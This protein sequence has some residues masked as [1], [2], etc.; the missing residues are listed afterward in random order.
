MCNVTTMP[1]CA[2]L[3]VCIKN[4][5]LAS[6]FTL[7]LGVFVI[8]KRYRLKLDLFLFLKHSSS[9]LFDFWASKPLNAKENFSLQCDGHFGHKINKMWLNTDKFFKPEFFFFLKNIKSRR[10]TNH[11]SFSA[12]KVKVDRVVLFSK[13][14]HNF[15]PCNRRH[16]KIPWQSLNLYASIEKLKF[17]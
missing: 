17:H 10:V 5:W 4:L 14:K 3:K 16:L 11:K 13:K 6:I 8:P 7:S 9:P 1:W 15:L 12:N 2:M